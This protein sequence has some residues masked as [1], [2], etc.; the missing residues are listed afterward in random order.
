MGLHKLERFFPISDMPMTMV[1]VVNN[2]DILV[3]PLVELFTDRD[4]VPGFT[5]PSS[6]IIE[7]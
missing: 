7:P 6:M 3:P 5:S 2:P 1:P 4:Q